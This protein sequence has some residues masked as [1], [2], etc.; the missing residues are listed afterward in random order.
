MDTAGLHIAGF[1]IKEAAPLMPVVSRAARWL[2]AGAGRGAA[3]GAGLGAAHGLATRQEGETGLSAAVRGGI[4]GGAVGAVGGGLG[5]AY[6]DTRLLNPGMSAVQG[7]G[8]TASRIGQGVKNFGKRQLHGLTGAYGDQAGQIGL[9]SSGTAQKKIDILRERYVDQLAHGETSAKSHGALLKH[10]ESLKQTGRIGDA[11]IKAGITNI[12]GLVRGL[13]KNPLQTLKAVKND[14]LSGG[15]VAG[16]LAPTA[17]LSAPDLA[18]GDESAKGGR[19]MRQKVVGVGSG[20]A[21]SAMTGGMPIIPQQLA[22]TGVERGMSLLGGRRKPK[23][24]MSPAMY[25]GEP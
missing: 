13:A 1:L 9:R 4:R 19:T 14:A 7:V 20:L 5:R 3:V 12:P 15:S 2:T 11:S 16:V 22:Y 6:R 24:P 8:A 25:P 10:I 23:P 21:A 17:L 18:K